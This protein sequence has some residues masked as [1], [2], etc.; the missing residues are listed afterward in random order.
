VTTVLTLDLGTSATKAA[1]WS[2]SEL[3][4]IAR[5]PLDTTHPR[6]GWAE[7]E[8][9]TWW[10]SVVDACAETRALAPETYSGIE[11]VG[12]SAAR[13]TFAL[14]DETLR[15]LGPGILWSDQRGGAFVDRF[16]DPSAFRS[17]TGVVL[18]GAS[19]VAKLA[20][21][22]EHERDRFAAAR[23]VL[24]PRDFVLARL[25]GDEV[26]TDPTLASR[27]GWYRL[28]GAPAEHTEFVG[29]RLPRVVPSASVVR[30]S[31][32]SAAGSDALTALALDSSTAI[33]VGAGDRAC[34]VLG[35]GASPTM[36]MVSWGTTTNVSIPVSDGA[37]AAEGAAVSRAAL[38]GFLL[39]AGLSA[40]GA[41]FGWLARLTGWHHDALFD[42]AAD[43]APGAQGLHA[44]PWF[45]GARAP[46][47]Q[48]DAHAAFVG[49]TAGH[50]PAELAR[51]RGSGCPRRRSLRRARRARRRRPCARRHR[52]RGRPLAIGTRGGVSPSHRSTRARP[53][54]VRRRAAH[55]RCRV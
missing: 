22:A 35:V 45:H 5:G 36:P 12:F 21:V 10:R 47:W 16:G 2:G 54:R 31:N 19:C 1:L 50:G 11:A 52:R 42:G 46:W 29:G 41:A 9:E 53:G 23:W 14:F 15:P 13:E 43:V 28:N 49:V 17:A 24:A 33:V 4:A 51:A 8:P 18:N 40:S 32:A 44:L 38:D 30:A 55:R 39:E 20:W 3:V 7:Q 27:T 37:T 6:P 26:V 25:L 48:P 34:E